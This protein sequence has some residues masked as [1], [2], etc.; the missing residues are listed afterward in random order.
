MRPTSRSRRLPA[1]VGAV[2]L[3]TVSLAGCTAVPGFG[4][5]TP[6]L[7]SGD[8]SSIVTAGSSVGSKPDVDFPT[9]L[10]AGDAAE[11]TVLVAGDGEPIGAGAQADYDF[12]LYDGATGELLGTS[13]YDGEQFS[14]QAT[15]L[16]GNAVSEALTCATVGSRVAVVGTWQQ[17]S[18]AFDP[19]AS[20]SMPEDATVVAVI[21]VRGA[22][23]GKAD[24]FNQLP[25]DGMPTVV[26]AVDGTPGVSVLLQEPPTE[27]RHS[28]IKGGG[29]AVLREDDRAVVH[30]SLWSW[31]TDGG[32][33]ELIGSTW[34]RDQAVTLELTSIDAGGG[35]PDG[36]LDALVGAKVGSQ[37]LA[38]LVPGDGSFPEGQGPSTDDTTYIFVVDVLGIEDA[39]D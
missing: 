7:V 23:L 24:G 17:V 16:E 28:T 38:V 4:G 35:V 2:A 19:A 37:V 21:D 1:L 32:D 6:T 25:L 39:G 14:R 29:G 27:T 3:V 13:G 5:C 34:T 26:T 15:G 33:P 11:A 30:Y 10:A 36:L 20:G 12:A 31:P 22:Y 18:G 8:A 9:P